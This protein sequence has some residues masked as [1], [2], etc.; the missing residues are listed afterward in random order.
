V[1]RQ[2]RVRGSVKVLLHIGQER[3]GSQGGGKGDHK[4]RKN[5]TGK[6]VLAG[7]EEGY[8]G[9]LFFLDWGRWGV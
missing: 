7:G 3:E 5:H 2:A 8:E 4:K 1:C 6:G 9:I